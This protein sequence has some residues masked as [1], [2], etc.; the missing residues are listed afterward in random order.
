VLNTGGLLQYPF[1][2]AL[3]KYGDV[4]IGDAGPA[5]FNASRQ[6]PGFIVVVPHGGTAFKLSIGVAVTF[7]QALTVNNVTGDLLIGDGGDVS[8]FIGQLVKVTPA[9]FASV[10]SITS[11]EVVTDPSGLTFDAAGNL[12]VLDGALNTITV[13]SS[14]GSTSLLPGSDSGAINAG[15]AIASSAGSQS[16]VVT[17]LG[18]GT[19]NSLV[20]LNGN[21]TTVAYGNQKVNTS[22]ASQAATVTN[23]G[24]A[25]L[26]L[27]S[28]FYSPRPIPGFAL[29]TDET[30]AG[31]LALTASSPS[32]SFAVDFSP[33]IAGG[34]SQSVKINS[35]AYNAGTPLIRLSGKGVR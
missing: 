28:S 9:G 33:T 3:N 19:A 17:N 8:D 21:S 5:G 29:A 2:L 6:E 35:N 27:S 18:G 31:G 34:V 13:V 14:T 25:T 15:S 26:T 1:A 30:C 23:I 10:V 22:S 12:Y 11:P 24:N 32:C 7:P 4:F 16:F 20:F